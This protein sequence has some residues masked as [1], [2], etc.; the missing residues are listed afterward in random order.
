MAEPT[1]RVL[2]VDD[3]ENI[4]Y[5]VASAMRLEGFAT[6]VA[7][8][9]REAIAAVEDSRPDLIILDV[10]LPD[11]D[12]FEVLRRLREAGRREPVIF[13]T[14]KD[15]TEDRVRGLTVGGDDYVVKPFAIEELLARVQ[16]VLR[17]T[18][19][20]TGD[21]VLR[22]ADLEL[23]D[24]AH[25]VTRGERP[26]QLSP[27]EYKLLRYLLANAERVMSRA[28]I[29]DHV[30]EYDFGGESSV[31][32]TFISYLRRKIDS[33]GPALIQTVRGVGYTIRI[34]H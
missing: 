14:A 3:E 16:A 20:L 9:G 8:T 12:G 2:V 27:T 5:L 28:Q 13:L 17:R 23:D 4:S 29:L 19:Q 18:G 22:Y 10:M 30:W 1:V 6:T 11:L 7:A 31:V 26:I 32:E 24:D 33:D 15:A 25:R 34:E 21:A